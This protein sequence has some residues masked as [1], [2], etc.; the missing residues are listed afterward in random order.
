MSYPSPQPAATLRPPDLHRVANDGLDAAEP[1]VAIAPP[2]ARGILRDEVALLVSEGVEH[3]HTEFL[4]LADYLHPGDLLVVNDSATLPASLE[5]HSRLGPITLNLSAR[6][7][8][9][10]WL[11][12]PRWSPASPGPLPLHA[13]EHLSVAGRPVR[14]V[15]PYPAHERLWFVELDAD[16]AMSACGRPIRYG[17]VSGEYPLRAYQ[18]VF[19]DAPG[20]AE[21]PSAG[22]PFSVRALARLERAGVRLATITLHTGVSS[23]EYEANDLS[24]APPE[25]YRVPHATAR[26]IIRAR[27]GG[28]RVLAIGTTVVRALESAFDGTAFDRLSG[29]TRRM[30]HPGRPPRV[31]DGLLTGFHEPR[32][33]HMALLVALAGEPT[34]EDA[35]R[36]AIRGRYLWHEFGDVHLIL[37]GSLR[38][39]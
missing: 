5:A 16:S 34:V 10:S 28:A 21:M 11:A 9:C 31:V 15:A 2:E 22:R 20:S 26:A 36:E 13:G 8:P 1:P 39:R 3:H 38:R 37:P 35:Y 29:F 14:L 7:G 25:P 32:S 19:A 24:Q 30:L 33:S 6:F 23:L 18:T 12:E 17:Y 4:D 27:A